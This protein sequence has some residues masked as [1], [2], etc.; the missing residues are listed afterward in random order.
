MSFLPRFSG[1][2]RAI[3]ILGVTQIIAWGVLFYPPV[4][5]LPAIAAERGWS[6]TFTMGGFSFGLLVAGLVAPFVGSSIDR[7][8]GH[9]MLPA[10][11]L[12]GA[13]GLVALIN[14]EHP[15]AYIA[16]WAVLGAAIAA[17]LYDPAFATL[18]RIFGAGARRPITLLTFFGG[19]ASTV[20]WPVTYFLMEIAGWRGAYT[21]YA[22]VLACFCAPLIAVTL[23]REKAQAGRLLDGTKLPKTKHIKAA[24]FAFFVVI[25]SFAAYAFVPSALSAHMLSIFDRLG[26]D[27][28]TAVL[29]GTLFGP[30]QV[31]ARLC[32]FFFARNLHP[33]NIA[34]FAVGL[35]IFAFVLLALLGVSTPVAFAFAIM[36]GV[37]NGL[38]TLCRGSVPLALF[39]PQG[40]GR[41]IGRIAGPS[42]ILQAAAPLV[43]AFVIERFSDAA[44][45]TVMAAVVVI[46]LFGFLA[47]RKP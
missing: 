45:L 33:L 10:G 36:F 30:A 20:S 17:S 35:L 40:Y 5:T 47:V 26:L 16:I 39:G 22:I 14:I 31:S 41:T 23:P 18:G 12:I 38:I 43:I 32:E 19:F 3:P 46:S 11:S 4:L 34:R 24:G 28:G 15:A 25:A 1:P 7:Y 6:L 8:G 37:A 2:W 9:T 21:V 44:G 29:M 13:A 42:L 27:K